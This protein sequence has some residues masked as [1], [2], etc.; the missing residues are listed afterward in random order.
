MND[1]M[2]SVAMLVYNH[3]KY[4]EQAIESILMQKVNFKYEIIIGEDCST[5]KSREIISKY[6]DMYP[7]IIKPIF[8][9]KN[10]GPM[11]NCREVYLNCKGKYIALLEGDDYW[12]DENKLQ[13]QVDFLEENSE[14]SCCVHPSKT[15]NCRTKQFDGIIPKVKFSEFED[16]NDGMLKY[17]KVGS[18]YHGNSF[19]FRNFFNKNEKM[20]ELLMAS[21]LVGDLQLDLINL[22]LGKFKCI[23]REMSVYRIASGKDCISG[24]DVEEVYYEYIKVVEI[25][26]RL[27]EYKYTETLNKLKEKYIKHIN[28]E[29]K[30]RSNK[31]KNYDFLI[32]MINDLCN[33]TNSKIL[34]FAKRNK[35]DLIVYGF[36]SIGKLLYKSLV[37]NNIIP[38]SIIDKSIEYEDEYIKIQKDILLDN[39]DEVIVVTAINYADDIKKELLSKGKRKVLSIEEILL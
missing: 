1:I 29:K 17:I 24:R 35:D 14:Y 27:F 16:L 19:L 28:D 3:E 11:K 9:C 6:R 23:D 20:M 4:I 12:C 25:A 26:D 30:V 38:Q 13:M 2:V 37:Y 39:E 32:L 8:R 33:S 31:V 10:I 34:E 18:F 22:H 21:E 5:D 7:D 36:G 15:Y